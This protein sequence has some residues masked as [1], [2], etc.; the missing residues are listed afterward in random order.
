MISREVPNAVQSGKCGLGIRRDPG[1]PRIYFHVGRQPVVLQALWQGCCIV[2][3]GI[4]CAVCVLD[5]LSPPHTG[6]QNTDDTKCRE[7]TCHHAHACSTGYTFCACRP[8][9]SGHGH[10][11]SRKSCALAS[12]NLRSSGNCQWSPPVSFGLWLRCLGIFNSAP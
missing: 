10:Y 8:K 3:I 2:G 11:A 5:V 1:A 6:A 7:Y 9:K 12:G 4:C